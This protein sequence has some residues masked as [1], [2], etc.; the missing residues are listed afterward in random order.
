MEPIDET[1]AN[2][3]IR[4]RTHPPLSLEADRIDSVFRIV[5][6]AHFLLE[7]A[8][9]GTLVVRGKAQRFLGVS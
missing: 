8:I 5:C 2:S 9:V 7:T 3:R 4:P 1:K 6:Y